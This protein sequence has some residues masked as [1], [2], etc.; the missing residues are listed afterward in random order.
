MSDEH[1][2]GGKKE[3][4][5]KRARTRNEKRSSRLSTGR[6]GRGFL[7]PGNTTALCT[8]R[9]S[10]SWS[11]SWRGERQWLCIVTFD[12]MTRIL[13]VGSLGEVMTRHPT[14]LSPERP[15]NPPPPPVSLRAPTS[16]WTA[17]AASSPSLKVEW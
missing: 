9:P 1:H 4:E 6:M 8:M 16:V 15:S 13:E 5:A 10:R 3:N 2:L 14:L 12:E 11:R 17:I 7:S